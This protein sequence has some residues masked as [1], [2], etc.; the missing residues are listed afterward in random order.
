MVA[1]AVGGGAAGH[2]KG[3]QGPAVKGAAARDDR[4]PSARVAGKLQRRLDRLRPRIA[5]EEHIQASRGDREE[6]LR[7]GDRRL[8]VVDTAGVYE[9]SQLL[10]DG[11]E[12]PRVVVPHVQDG[13]SRG[14]VE[15]APSVLGDDC[16]PLAAGYGNRVVI[17]NAGAK[18]AK[19]L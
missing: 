17:C 7:C 2:R 16:G 6:F 10:P 18:T 9:A 3:A 19:A 8:A 13:K 4:L 5:E 12:H 1:P 14:E 11:V 15:K